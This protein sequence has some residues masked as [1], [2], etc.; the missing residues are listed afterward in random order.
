MREF[1]LL[2]Q[3]LSRRKQTPCPN[4]LVSDTDSTTTYFIHTHPAARIAVC[5]KQHHFVQASKYQY[6]VRFRS[7]GPVTSRRRTRERVRAEDTYYVLFTSAGAFTPTNR[8]GTLI[9]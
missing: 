1:S 7:A 2:C 8:G 3:D 9:V 4:G 5:T 6:K